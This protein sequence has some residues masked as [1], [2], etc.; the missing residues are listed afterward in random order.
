[1]TTEKINK[2]IEIPSD[3]RYIKKVSNEILK[4]L[5]HFG[6]DKSFQFDVRLA[7]EEAIRNAIEHGH[8]YEKELPITI[9]YTVDKDK[10]EVVVEDK[11]RGFDLKKVPDPRMEDNIT[12]EGGRGVFLIH[13]LMDEARYN[14]RGNKVK[15]TKFF[16]RR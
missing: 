12:K 1:M 13:R 9:S 16:K 3:I 2:N 4:L 11:G 14:R 6:V 10:I 15:M 5:E 7:V 8:R